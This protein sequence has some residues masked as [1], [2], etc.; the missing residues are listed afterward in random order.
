MA[1]KI[2]GHIP[3]EIGRNIRPRGQIKAE[4]V[5]YCSD[6]DVNLEGFSHTP[7]GGYIPPYDSLGAENPRDM[8]ALSMPFSN[9]SA[10]M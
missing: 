9:T 3:H 5:V 8:V 7:L 2:H 6:G 1:R 10:I 4:G